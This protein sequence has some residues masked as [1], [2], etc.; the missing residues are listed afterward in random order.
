[1]IK[2]NKF[3]QNCF[4][5][6]H[7]YEKLNLVCTLATCPNKGLICSLCKMDPYNLTNPHENHQAKIVPFKY[8]IQTL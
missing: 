2:G 3:L 8:L 4:C 5:D 1:M 7:P 6:E